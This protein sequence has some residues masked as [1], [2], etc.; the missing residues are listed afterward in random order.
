MANKVNIIKE[1]REITAAGMTD[2]KKALEKAGGNKDK[3]LDIL[4][5]QGLDIAKK[6]AG[7]TA[8]EG[9][10]ESYVHTG[11]KLGVLVEVNCE[12]D[13]VARNEEFIRFTKD[14][15]MQIAATAPTY[16]DF[17]SVSSD[18]KKEIKKEEE[19]EY[20]KVHCLLEQPFI[21]E[22]S[23]TA[24]DCLVSLIAKMGENIIIKRFVRFSIG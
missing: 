18:L 15:A 6:K 13:F 10:V 8:G 14:I 20:R 17:E 21:K 12:T 11:S 24:G 1:L 3:A 4:R 19:A 5:R 23:K 22:A 7:R 2:C 9:R 16:V